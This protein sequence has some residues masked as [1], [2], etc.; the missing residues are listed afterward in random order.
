MIDF[1]LYKSNKKYIFISIII[2]IFVVFFNILINNKRFYV[3]ELDNRKNKINKL[4]INEIM[5]SNKGAMV[6]ENGNKYDWIELYNG[7]DEAVDLTDYGLSDE[8]NGEVK[9]IFPSV[10]IDSKSYLVVF[11]SGKNDKGLH[12]NFSLGQEGGE[13]ISLKNN[14]G[15][16]VDSV[17]TVDI[18]KNNTMARN[19]NGDWLVTADITPGFVNND[20]GR[21]EFLSGVIKT[22]KSGLL[23]LS[24]FLPSNEGNVIFNDNKLYGYVEVTNY[25]KEVINLYDYYLSND[26]YV[27]YKWRFPKKE[28]NPGET[29]VVFVNGL[30]KENCAS[31]DLKHKVGSLILSTYS[32]VVEK[33]DYEGLTNGV[34]YVKEN[35][36]WNQSAD[37]SPGYINSDNGIE[38]FRKN[39][40]IAKK[41]LIINEAMSSNKWYLPQN[42]YQ[43]YDWIEL[44]NNSDTN[45]NL[46]DYSL[47][48]DV[49]DKE[50]YKLPN[51]ILEPNNYYLVMASGDV[52]LSNNSYIHANFKLS[53]G[54]GLL[55]YKNKKL[56]DSMYLYNIPKGSSYGRGNNNGHY[57]YNIPTPGWINDTNGL[58]KIADESMFSIPGGVY[59]NVSSLK[60]T[61]HGDEDI[62]YTLDGSVP[63]NYSLKYSLPIEITNTTVI[64]AV[65]YKN[66]KQNSEVITNS[67]II[68][69]NHTIPVVSLSMPEQYFNKVQAS[70][71]GKTSAKAHAE[72]YEF[73]SSFS[74]DCDFKLFGGQSRTLSKKSFALKFNYQHLNYKVFD[75]KDIYEFNT[76]VLRSGSQE[77][78]GSM[79]R[80]ELLTSIAYKYGTL[81][82]QAYKP[83]VLYINGKYWGV[84]YLREKIEDDFIQNN[85]NVSGPTNIVSSS[86]VAEEGINSDVVKLK[87]YVKNHDLRD[88]DN[89]LYVNGLLDVENYIDFWVYQ[90][91]LNNSD[92]H[93]FRYYNN[94]NVSSNRIRMIL[95]DLDYALYGNSG[96]YYLSY[97]QNPVG[98]LTYVDNS[99]LASLMKNEKFKKKF[100]DRLSYYMKNV[101]TSENVTREF[102]YIYNMIQPEMY[103]NCER[104]GY[105]Y[106][107]WLGY[108]RNLK[109]YALSR[110]S[111]VKYA[112]RSYFGLTLE[113]ANE[114]FY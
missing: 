57:Y 84:Y 55:L 83:V 38:A 75:N 56:V 14:Y 34:G 48:T 45:I 97:M 35:G 67:Y 29:Y 40:D 4:V 76:L 62:Y 80:D 6:D 87:N 8:I 5:T 70:P 90:F 92:L 99:I 50:M 77:Q 10:T 16:V 63:N 109:S 27:I 65:S 33:V 28:L 21:E 58:I 39:D 74:I 31:F 46:A 54:D 85:Y 3:S 19:S 52:S 114:Y 111:Q 64:R 113:E 69:E 22:K 108:T 1:E 101:W 112:A 51:I 7:Y 96:A 98:M 41:G 86:F 61:L 68:N 104:W 43:F 59:N 95:Y 2:I 37:I 9:W 23:E 25:S 107:V 72:L 102:D 18:D 47:T 17:K 94:P 60:I 66:G 103:R 32:G 15:K 44:Y 73:D 42:G 88:E 78:T 30:D 106:N 105:D 13:L 79:M 20:S 24:E 100:L 91:I 81:D 110:N 36:I 82:A 12:A 71:Y 93:N 89:Y 26:S 11:L 49:D 53:S